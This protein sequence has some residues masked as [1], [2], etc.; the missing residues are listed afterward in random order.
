[1]NFAEKLVAKLAM[2]SAK[3]AARNGKYH[4]VTSALCLRAE[5]NTIVW[6]NNLFVQR[7][8]IE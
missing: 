8:D 7:Q 1:M 2:T 3:T 6:Q 5:P 4:L